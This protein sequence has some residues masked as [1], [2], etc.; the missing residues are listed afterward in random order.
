M[1]VNVQLNALVAALRG[2]NPHHPLNKRL[3]GIHGLLGHFGEEN[4]WRCLDKK[5]DFWVANVKET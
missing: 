3:T 4:S 2:N 5:H 1:Q